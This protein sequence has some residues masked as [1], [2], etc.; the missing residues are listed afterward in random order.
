MITKKRMG[1]YLDRLDRVR[2]KR[3]KRYFHKHLAMELSLSQIVRTAIKSYYNEFMLDGL[4][5]PVEERPEH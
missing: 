3:L 1:F 4:V 2:L 5:K